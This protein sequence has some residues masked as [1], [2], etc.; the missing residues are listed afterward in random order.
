MLS[1]PTPE[2][3]LTRRLNPEDLPAYDERV[4]IWA[5]GILA[6]ELL[7]GR[8]PFEVEDM[9]ETA[10]LIKHAPVDKF[11]GHASP[12]CISF[13]QQARL[14]HLQFVSLSVQRN[15]VLAGR[16]SRRRHPGLEVH[17]VLWAP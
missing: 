7:A 2:E 16:T 6:Y 3:I 15:S 8:P 9:Q 11:P 4:D 17:E 12:A 1:I 5:V 10:E 14:S 13:I